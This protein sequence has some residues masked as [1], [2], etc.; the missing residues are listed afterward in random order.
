MT[1]LWDAYD[2][3]FNKIKGMTLVRG[4]SIPDGV[5][6]LVC[7]IV[8][9]HTDGSYLLMQRDF[10]K[11]Y[12]GMWELTAGLNIY[13]LQIAIRIPLSFKKERPLIING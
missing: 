10:Q 1:E 12:G 5:Y 7:D 4:E 11:T 13:V 6:H 3:T 2:N 8:V 9:K